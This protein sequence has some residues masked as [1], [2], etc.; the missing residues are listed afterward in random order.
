M[1]FVLMG[2]MCGGMSAGGRFGRGFWGCWEWVW[3]GLSCVYCRFCGFSFRGCSAA[4]FLAVH[5]EVLVR[6]FMGEFFHNPF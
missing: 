2:W 4:V 3:A 5:W 6:P 1:V